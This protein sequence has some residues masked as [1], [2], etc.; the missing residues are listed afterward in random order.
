MRR[1]SSRR[2]ALGNRA[3]HCPESRGEELP[4]PQL[5]FQ[6]INKLTGEQSDDRPMHLPK[7]SH[8]SGFDKLFFIL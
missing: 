4:L 7:L 8:V 3:D 1:C 5:K 6:L 2:L